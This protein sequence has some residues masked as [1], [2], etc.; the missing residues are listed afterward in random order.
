MELEARDLEIKPLLSSS[1]NMIR[2]KTLMHHIK[3]STDIKDLPE[4]INADERKLKQI[5][6]N[7]LSNAVKFTPEGGDIHL[8]AKVIGKAAI[9]AV[10]DG[11]PLP[12]SDS[13]QDSLNPDVVNP[14]RFMQIVVEDNG[15]GIKSEDLERI[16]KPF[17]QADGSLKRRYQ[18]TGLGLSLTK[19]LVELH[20]GRIWVE[21]RGEGKGST[22]YIVIPI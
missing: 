19:Q 16:L 17:E 7:L 9:P 8:S 5:L 15:I 18:G 20:G 1:L 6:Y 21:S 11:A 14:Q 13:T 3:L 22:F 12:V 2:E 10:H 4:T